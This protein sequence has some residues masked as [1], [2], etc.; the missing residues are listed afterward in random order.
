M[1]AG[2]QSLL[3]AYDFPGNVRELK[4]IIERAVALSNGEQITEENLFGLGTGQSTVINKTLK[5]ACEEF[6]KNYIMGILKD[7]DYNQ[8][9]TSKILNIARTTLA[10]R[11][12][13]LNIECK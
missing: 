9:K 8:T 1:S 13:A 10:S 11:M 7:V 6:E 5:D 3:M 2:A 4:N 12:K